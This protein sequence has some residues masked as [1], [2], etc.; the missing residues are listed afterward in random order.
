MQNIIDQTKI[1]DIIKRYEEII[2]PGNK[3]NKI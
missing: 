2:K 3:N 1:I